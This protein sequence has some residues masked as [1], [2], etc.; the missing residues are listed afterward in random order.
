MRQ[1]IRRA[2]RVRRQ[3]RRLMRTVEGLIEHP[4]D[5]ERFCAALGALLQRTITLWPLP[6]PADAPARWSHR[7]AR[8]IRLDDGEDCVFYSATAS[9]VTA[10]TAVC[11]ELGHLIGHELRHLPGWSWGEEIEG[12]PLS[13][14][15]ARHCFPDVPAGQVRGSFMASRST[16]DDPVEEGVERFSAMFTRRAYPWAFQPEAMTPAEQALAEG[17]GT[18]LGG[19]PPHRP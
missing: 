15:D 11:H 10:T 18:V 14:D 13:P 3:S 7:S 8:W 6:D 4:F 2:W 17:W 1:R 5:L 19:T 16:Y 12:L 9:P